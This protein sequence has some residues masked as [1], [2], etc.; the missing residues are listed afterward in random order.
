MP[1]ILRARGLLRPVG[2]GLSLLR[3]RGEPWR[4]HL[5]LPV[6]IWGRLRNSQ[7]FSRTV[8]SNF[9]VKR[10]NNVTIWYF[11]CLCCTKLFRILISGSTKTRRIA[12][13]R[14]NTP[15]R[16]VWTLSDAR[17]AQRDSSRMAKEL[18]N[19]R[20]VQKLKKNIMIIVH[21]LK[22]IN[23]FLNQCETGYFI[24]ETQEVGWNS[25]KTVCRPC[26]K[27]CSRCHGMHA[28]QCK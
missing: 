25:M 17:I 19:V 22:L 21:Y 7:L 12:A 5:S 16:T 9:K 23:C 24:D 14:A 27:S 13:A 28:N 8:C 2:V 3:Q 20:Y 1:P 15:A 6:S 18:A 26:H 4:H 11:T 10:R